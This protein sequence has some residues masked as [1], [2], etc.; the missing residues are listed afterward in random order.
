M[1]IQ[2]VCQLCMYVSLTLTCLKSY[3]H[4]LDPESRQKVVCNT[5]THNY[6]TILMRHVANFDWLTIPIV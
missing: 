5:P 4:S 1:L 3:L 2:L 6:D